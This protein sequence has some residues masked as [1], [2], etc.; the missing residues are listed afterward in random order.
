VHQLLQH[1]RLDQV[2][3]PAEPGQV[4]LTR[5]LFQKQSANREKNYR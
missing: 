2:E 4:V 5:V 1:H 3:D